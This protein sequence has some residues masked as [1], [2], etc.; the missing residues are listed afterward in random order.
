MIN[1]D[2]GN[3]LYLGAFGIGF[4]CLCWAVFKPVAA[5]RKSNAT[6]AYEPVLHKCYETPTHVVFRKDKPDV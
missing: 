3:Y 1:V 5:R 4:V 2:F 6:S